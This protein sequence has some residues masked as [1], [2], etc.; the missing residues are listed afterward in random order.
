MRTDSREILIKPKPNRKIRAIFSTQHEANI[1]LGNA[2]AFS[3]I[4][5]DLI[6]QQ[7]V[8]WGISFKWLLPRSPIVT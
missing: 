6:S 4:G 8:D 1:E 2:K 7:I 5:G 3:T